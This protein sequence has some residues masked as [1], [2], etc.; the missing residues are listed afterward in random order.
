MSYLVD[1]LYKQANFCVREI[2]FA[3]VAIH[4]K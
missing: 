2:E 1:K 3:E 4:F